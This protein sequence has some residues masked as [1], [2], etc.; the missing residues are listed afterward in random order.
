MLIV[1]KYGGTSVGTPD[2][3]RN[4]AER[5]V[6]EKRAGHE[7]V[8]VVSA[9]ADST[10]DLIELA[11]EVSPEGRRRHPRERHEESAGHDARWPGLPRGNHAAFYVGQVSNGIYVVDQWT[12]EDK[13]TIT[14]RFI[15]IKKTY[16]DGTFERPSDNAAAFSVIE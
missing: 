15:Y 1:Q 12:H 16:P 2:R 4:V 14:L 9:M 13:K 5:V 7:L 10:D 6:R 11:R 3:I 8:V